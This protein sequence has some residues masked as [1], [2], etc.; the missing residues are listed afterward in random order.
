MKKGVFVGS[1]DPITLGHYDIIQRASK[2][3]EHLVVG[4]GCNHQ[5]S[6]TFSAEKRKEF[7][8]LCFSE[9]NSIT[10]TTYEGLT[11]DFCRDI[12]ADCIIRGIRNTTDWEYEKS[13][14]QTNFQ[15]S[16]I[17]TVFLFTAPQLAH[18]SS[19]MVREIRLHGRDISPFVPDKIAEMITKI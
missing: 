5:K 18:I 16:G 6:Y 10:V 11:V 13:I 9:N 19:S 1:F 12:Q 2:L 15:L 8:T 7:V 3:V 14:A 4:I 17:E